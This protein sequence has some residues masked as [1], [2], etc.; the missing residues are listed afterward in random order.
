MAD[1]RS[2]LFMDDEGQLWEIRGR[3]LIGGVVTPDDGEEVV[4][5]GRSLLEAVTQ[6]LELQQ[7]DEI[8][9]IRP[10]AV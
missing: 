6:E 2:R 9:V 3:V 7:G 5:K 4:N 8:L 10:R 1:E